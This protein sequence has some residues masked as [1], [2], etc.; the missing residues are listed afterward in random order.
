MDL[1]VRNA[2]V[3]LTMLNATTF[4]VSMGYFFWALYHTLYADFDDAASGSAIDISP[5]R[6]GGSMRTRRC[7]S[8]RAEESARAGETDGL[9][10]S[11]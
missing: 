10:T 6:A 8:A 3:T 9:T 2:P 1:V 5:A 4:T 11:R 7:R